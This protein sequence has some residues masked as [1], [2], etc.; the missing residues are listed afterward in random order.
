MINLNEDDILEL[1][2]IDLA[3][4]EK[5]AFPLSKH[6]LI[7]KA[8]TWF[9]GREKILQETICNN[10][11]IIKYIKDNDTANLITAIADLIVSVTHGV[12]PITVAHL[13]VKK[14]LTIFC[15]KHLI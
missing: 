3:N 6:Q 15:E 2:G 7:Q 8:K 11:L 14:G 9:Y 12:S 4:S 5:N 13:I 1:I 10:E